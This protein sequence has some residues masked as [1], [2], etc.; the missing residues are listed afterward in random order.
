MAKK[1]DKTKQADPFMITDEEASAAQN[2]LS[3][4]STGI[5]CPKRNKSMGG[6]CKVCDYIQSQI[7]DK[8]FPKEHA[9]MT[10]A[11]EKKAKLSWFT[12]V[13]FPENPDKSILFEVGDKAGNQVV[14]GIN[15]LGWRDIVHPHKGIGRELIVIKTKEPG[16][17]WP[18][19]TITPAQDK[20][21]WEIPEEVWRNVYDL[22]DIINI[23]QT[24]ELTSENYKHVRSI[25]TDE[26]LNFRMCPPKDSESGDKVVI[27]AVYRH[28]G[29][30][31]DQ[32]NGEDSMN[33]R[34]SVEE[35]PADDSP[36]VEN[37]DSSGLDTSF[38][39]TKK[40]EVLPDK[41]KQ[42]PKL[43]NCFGMEQFFEIDDK[44]TCIPC[45][46]YKACGKKIAMG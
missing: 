25:K 14:K 29:V 13:V 8:K 39:D 12:N 38:M 21:D 33:W 42:G 2:Q 6:S 36:F 18:T 10:W 32:I 44:V 34:Q 24:T 41:T 40:E 5:M 26:T 35:D 45:G 20:A 22:N 3:K 15:K 19:Y 46:S 30:T 31:E 43:P 17:S 16:D 4:G 1:A 28:W 37:T 9:A 23:L 27:A 11:R 7:Y